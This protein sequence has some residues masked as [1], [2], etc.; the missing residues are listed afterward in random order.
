M[1][2]SSIADLR[3]V[4]ARA[5]SAAHFWDV[6]LEL[7]SMSWEGVE[8]QH[9]VEQ[10]I[11]SWGYVYQPTFPVLWCDRAS[12]GVFDGMREKV[13]ADG[14]EGYEPWIDLPSFSMGVSSEVFSIDE[15]RSIEQLE[16]FLVDWVEKQRPASEQIFMWR[17]AC[18]RWVYELDRDGVGAIT[19][20]CSFPETLFYELQRRAYAPTFRVQPHR[21][22][23][24]ALQERVE[25][26]MTANLK[27]YEDWACIRLGCQ[28][29]LNAASPMTRMSPSFAFEDLKAYLEE[30][31]GTIAKWKG[32]L[33]AEE[34]LLFNILQIRVLTG[35]WDEFCS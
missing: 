15:G 25:D 9:Y 7:S 30:A 5:C 35:L 24:E 33:P 22:H 17:L 6:C 16:G 4:F 27:A 20:I 3:G 13:L 12:F 26:E 11:E 32:L 29:L 14:G 34:I 19:G 23:F 31:A 1:T 21:N 2:F 28:V 18:A 10:H 8:V